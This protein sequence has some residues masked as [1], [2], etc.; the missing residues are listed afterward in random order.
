MFRDG[1]AVQAAEHLAAVTARP[2]DLCLAQDAQMPAHARLAH[3]AVVG[4]LGD[5]HLRGGGQAFDDE[6]PRGIGEALE[7]DGQIT[8]AG[9]DAAGQRAPRRAWGHGAV[10]VWAVCIKEPFIKETL[11]ILG[12]RR[13]ERKPQASGRSSSWTWSASVP[14]PARTLVS[15]SGPAS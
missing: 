3:L 7:V 1:F 8:S 9:R 2:D 13:P 15:M 14:P 4:Q 10:G 5:A 6:Q 12:A 11:C